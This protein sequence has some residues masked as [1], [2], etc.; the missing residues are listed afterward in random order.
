MSADKLMNRWLVVLGAVLIQLCLGAI[1][2]WS[3]FTP[4]LI[5][6]PYDFTAT[7]TQWIFGV[8]LASFA[9]TMIAAGRLQAK[10]APKRIAALGG[11]V[12]GLGYVAAS[13]V[14]TSFVGL[15]VCIGII[16]G[17]GIGLAYVV[18]IAVGVKWFPDRKGMLT[19]LAVA[20]FGFGALIWVKL[21]GSWGHLIEILGLSGVFLTYGIVF[22]AVVLLGSIW[23]VR[24]PEDYVPEGW[25]P[26]AATSA[27][28][29]VG[30]VDFESGS[31][32]KTPQFF[33]LWA[34]FIAGAMAGL[35]VIGCIK[36]FGI[37]TL[38]TTGMSAAEASAAAGT[39]M[40]V[41]YA[42]ANGLGRI[43]W[44]MVSDKLGRKL[45]LFL[46]LFI[47]G[48]VMLL[49]YKMGFSVATLYL[50]AAIIGFNFGGNFALFPAATADLFGNRNV[51]PNYGWVFTA[52]G[53][54]G[55]VGPV[56]A[57]RF[58][59]AAVGGDPSAWITPFIVA[60]VACLVASALTLLLKT[61]SKS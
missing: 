32:L 19:G 29:A 9:L 12:L 48:I 44:G 41:F 27:K 36:L 6:A 38:Q 11:I 18:P 60:G 57:G 55:I 3:V 53:V 20:G 34:M 45:S 7:Q 26:P 61:P 2:A 28:G 50:G 54:G 1:Y 21:A 39:A 25:T 33:A 31:M 59:S 4:E 30:V 58:R 5:K 37:D 23:M 8:G 49:F 51:G 43:G 14:G 24:P 17:A 40:A 42:L 10:Y 56:L 47:Q 35:M 52:Y 22:A 13:F 16:G 46:M 15:L